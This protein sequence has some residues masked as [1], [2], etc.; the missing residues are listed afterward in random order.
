MWNNTK[1]QTVA[2]RRKS[3]L[4]L[5][6]QCALGFWV[7]EWGET[8]FCHKTVRNVGPQLRVQPTRRAPPHRRDAPFDEDDFVF[9]YRQ[10]GERTSH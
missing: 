10:Q 3:L 5:I 6:S 9:L 2:H 1:Q 7:V 4:P 8:R